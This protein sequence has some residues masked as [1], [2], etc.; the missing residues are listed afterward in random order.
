MENKLL[1]KWLTILFCVFFLSACDSN[2]T[3]NEVSG[4][5]LTI[6]E[7][8]K[9]ILDAPYFSHPSDKEVEI[10]EITSSDIWVKTKFQL[11]KAAGETFIVANQEVVHIANGFGGY[12]VTSAVPYDVNKDG[13][14]DIIYTYSFGSGIHRSIISWIDLK[15]FKEH[16]VEDIPK[17]TGFRMYD[18]ILKNEKDETV[19]YRVMDESEILQTYPSDKDINQMTLKKDGIL[20]WENSELYNKQL[21]T[22]KH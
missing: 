19:V 21:Q 18:L 10:F 20:I 1:L 8:K 4:K 16:I 14:S 15:N 13:T 2:E 11:F 9:L 5:K 12:G 22:S 17:R 7:A 6:E 3:T